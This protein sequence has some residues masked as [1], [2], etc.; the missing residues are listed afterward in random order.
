MMSVD[1]CLFS[2]PL[3]CVC[4]TLLCFQRYSVDL[5]DRHEDLPLSTADPD[6]VFDN[7]STQKGDN[8]ELHRICIE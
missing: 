3:R 7:S 8:I 4:C 1:A 2:S 5:R 6:A